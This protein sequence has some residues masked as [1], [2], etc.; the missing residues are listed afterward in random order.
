MAKNMQQIIGYEAMLGVVKE[1]TSGVPNDLIP[2]AFL[3]MT[4]PVTGNTGK[5]IKVKGTRQTARLVHYGS[6]SVRRQQKGASEET[7]TLIHSFEHILHDIT[8]LTN[9]KNMNDPQRQKLGAQEIDRQ[10]KK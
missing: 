10:T 3:S 2:P 6:P 9:L 8:T 7:V 1:I 5:Y 4:R